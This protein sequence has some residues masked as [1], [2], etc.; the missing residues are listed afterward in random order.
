[1]SQVTE[2]WV[3][4][5]KR[6]WKTLLRRVDQAEEK[7]GLHKAT[8]DISLFFKNL[9]E[10][11]L[12]NKGFWYI[13]GP[14]S[15]TAPTKLRDKVTRLLKEVEEEVYTAALFSDKIDRRS[16]ERNAP[17]IKEFLADADQ[18]LSRK[19]FPLLK[20]EIKKVEK[21]D[22][23]SFLPNAI[24]VSGLK[25]VFED[26]ASRNPHQIMHQ[27]QMLPDS[28]ALREGF[29]EATTKAQ[30][31][32]SQKRMDHLWYG[33]IIVSELSHNALYSP[34]DDKVYL[35]TTAPQRKL[36]YLL[37]HELG[38]RHWFKFMTPHNRQAF[39]A[40]FHTGEVDPVTEYGG[41]MAEEDFAEVFAH[42]IVGR[43][44]SRDQKERF[45]EFFGGR[46]SSIEKRV[47]SL[48]MFEQILGV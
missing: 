27:T 37:I 32:L 3:S 35:A 45:Q 46:V 5:T 10:D 18:I 12:I 4:T 8:K 34:N 2:Q 41:T 47:A 23:G 26:G 31:L 42:Y 36:T 28:P 13:L 15:G 17:M 33:T 30:S 6:S 44:L 39:S 38:H 14:Y 25:L 48:Y 9:R 20:R 43:N 11:L 16:W 40:Y 19:L 22:M 29:L 1:M 7:R 24:D 21:L